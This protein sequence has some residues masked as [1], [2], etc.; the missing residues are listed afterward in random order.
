[1]SKL[2][3]FAVDLRGVLIGYA[4]ILLIAILS[5]PLWL[6]EILQ[7]GASIPGTFRLLMAW[8]AI[9]PGA[10]PIYFFT[11][12]PLV[13]AFGHSA[14]VARLPT[15]IFALAGCVVFSRIARRIPLQQPLL[16]TCLFVLVPI[17][18]QFATLAIST[19]EALLFLLLATLYFMRLVESE[20][21]RD[22]VF[23]AA[24]L[25]LCLYTEPM[26]YLPAIGYVLGL[27]VFVM[28]KEARRIIW[29]S[30]PATIAPVLLFLPF[31]LW[32]HPFASKAWLYE[33]DHFAIGPLAYLAA[34]RELSAPGW[35]GY[36]LSPLLLAGAAFGGWRAIRLPEAMIFKRLRLIC[37]LGGVVSTI[38]LALIID[39]T[40]SG[41]FSASQI[42]WTLPG[43]IVL[44]SAALDWVSSTLK[45]RVVAT[46]AAALL[47]LLCVG[48][49]I[50]NFTIHPY[51]VSQGAKLI[52]PLLTDDTC[53]VFVSE[54]L[55][56][57]IFSVFDPHL[58]KRQCVDFF[59][60]RIVLASHP[61]V[62]ADQ[63][64]DAETYFRGLNFVETQR[65]EVSGSKIIV[66]QQR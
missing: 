50:E 15:L 61:F 29:I 62:R 13:V 57:S 3:G 59:H 64:E 5:T 39:S 55:S 36:L 54:T 18:Y 22:A 26:S 16:A 53:L 20:S 19:E 56:E 65:M 30:L 21:I 42:F 6:S 12:F 7:L 47:M 35:P 25:L 37:V 66:V 28:R 11:E 58:A 27:L 1:M 43:L 49:D 24:F 2:S 14:F 48:G 9:T 40:S 52:G 8:M 41:F 46:S 17:H 4:V 44:V 51:D 63:Q 31:A 45:M 34:F 10:T 33:G 38:V 23:Y 32:S 60:K